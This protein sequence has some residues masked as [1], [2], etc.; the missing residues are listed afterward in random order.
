MS[1][2]GYSL[3]FEYQNIAIDKKDISKII[4]YKKHFFVDNLIE[5][6]GIN[7]K[8]YAAILAI[9]HYSDKTYNNFLHKLNSI[10]C[11]Y[12]NTHIFQPVNINSAK[13]LIVKQKNRLNQVGDYAI[14]QIE[15][16]DTALDDLQSQRLSF[17]YHSNTILVYE[18]NIN[19]LDEKLNL[20]SRIFLDSGIIV[21]RE[22]LNL[23]SSYISILPANFYFVT[24]KYLI[25]SKNFIDLLN[26]EYSD[27]GYIDQNHLGHYLMP[28]KKKDNNLYKF[29]LHSIGDN[30]KGHSLLISPT[31]SGK[32]TLMLAIDAFSQQYGGRRYFFDRNLGMKNYVD[33]LKGHYFIINPNHATRINPI[34]KYDTRGNRFFLYEFI[35]SLIFATDELIDEV[36]SE[37]IKNAIDGVYSLDINNRNLSNLVTFFSCNWKYLNRFNIWLKS[38]DGLLSW[39]FDNNEDEFDL[40][41]NIIGIDFTHILNNKKALLPL[42]QLLF[43]RIESSLDGNLTGIYLDEAWQFFNHPYWDI[44]INEYQKTFR[45]LNAYLFFATQNPHDI[46]NSSLLHT[47]TENIA[48]QI[49]MASNNLDENLYLNNFGLTKNEVDLLKSLNPNKR[50]ILIKQDNNVNI[51]NFD[52]K[53]LKKYLDVFS[54]N[55]KRGDL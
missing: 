41:N 47:I 32:T 14:S 28:F 12:I 38:S 17:G 8:K 26:L 34:P 35:K 19:T 25:S 13:D 30:S 49:Y 23:E 2:L 6:Q 45:K 33:T 42:M 37:E 31:G 53:D 52:L 9:K 18:D 11:S 3:N 21:T 4:N 39:V 36:D 50:E 22:A 55:I 7:N 43:F 5:I 29:N 1:F 44:K 54:P 27:T 46:A 51:L 24:R 10:N 15:E 48:A 16:L 40:T 20:I